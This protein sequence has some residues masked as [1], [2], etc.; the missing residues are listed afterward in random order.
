MPSAARELREIVQH[1]L[2]HLAFGLKN[3]GQWEGAR[4]WWKYDK[5]GFQRKKYD[6][7]ECHLELENNMK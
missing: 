7:G 3:H 5:K 4:I 1:S 2:D 6:P